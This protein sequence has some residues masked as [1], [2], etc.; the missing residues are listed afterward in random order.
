MADFMTV[1]VRSNFTCNDLRVVQHDDNNQPDELDDGNEGENHGR[2]QIF[3]STFRRGDEGGD[4]E[5]NHEEQ[6]FWSF[7]QSASE[8]VASTILAGR[9]TIIRNY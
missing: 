3:R 1:D 5:D 9:I 8:E 6:V 7:F 2:A 4:E